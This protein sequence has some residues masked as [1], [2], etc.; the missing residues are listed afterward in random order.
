MDMARLTGGR[1]FAHHQRLALHR[2][3]CRVAGIAQR[4]A[5]NPHPACRLRQPARTSRGP[6]PARPSSGSGNAL[7]IATPGTCGSPAAPS[8]LGRREAFGVRRSVGMDEQV[9]GNVRLNGNACPT[10]H[11]RSKLSTEAGSVTIV[12]VVPGQSAAGQNNQHQR[13]GE[14]MVLGRRTCAPEL[15][16][17]AGW[18]RRG[19]IQPRRPVKHQRGG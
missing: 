14:Q 12:V 16:Q 19:A 15:R 9:L 10:R 18:S 17:S 7:T 8:A 4:S 13:A 6:A 5:R 3:I 2:P 1:R 11:T